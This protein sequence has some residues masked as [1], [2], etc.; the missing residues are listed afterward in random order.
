MPTLDQHH[1]SKIVK[2]LLIGN[3]GSGKT[4]AFSA[5]ANAGFKLR[6]LDYDNGLDSLAHFTKPEFKPNISF[7]TLTDKLKLVGQNIV[8][9]GI[10][11]AFTQ[12]MQLLDKWTEGE[13]NLGPITTWGSDT[14]FICDS[15]TFLGEAILR[16]IRTL[17]SNTGNTTITQWG[18]AMRKQEEF[19]QMMYSTSIK[20]NVII[21]SHL[22][23]MEGEAGLQ[24]GYPSA[25]G[26]KLPPKVAR[27]FNSILLVKSIGSGNAQR[28]MIHT[29]SAPTIDLKN[30]IP[31]S[32]PPELDLSTGLAQFFKACGVGVSSTTPAGDK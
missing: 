4:G 1:S 22:T 16:Y 17:A 9:D 6:I 26:S 23:F 25:L 29:R 27:Y 18:E 20:C 31:D 8:P 10:P 19:L 3:S 12:G 14:V 24:M 11:T 15:L 21:T 13:T 7:H 2:I 5:L 32:V 28:R 30:P